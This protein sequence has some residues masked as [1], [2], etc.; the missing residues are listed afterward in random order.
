M[1]K[2]SYKGYRFP[3]EIIQQE[4]KECKMK[5]RKVIISIVAAT[6]LAASSEP[7]NAQWYGYGYDPAPAIFAG[8]GL[9]LFTGIRAAQ[10]AQQYGYPY[11]YG[12]PYPYGYL[13][14]WHQPIFGYA[15]EVVGWTCRQLWP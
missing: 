9:A 6:V 2:I 15:G 10:V 5:V 12:Y 11:A 1:K 8:A 3:P 14:C 4:L 13:P 7:S